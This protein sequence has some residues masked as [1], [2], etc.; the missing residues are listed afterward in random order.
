M[1]FA[2][3]NELF[4]PQPLEQTLA[5]IASIGYQG[6][7]LA[8]FTLASE[9]GRLSPQRRR[10][11]R[12]A[13]EREGLELI[14]LHWLLAQTEGLHLTTADNATRQRTM[15]YLRELGELCHDLGGG[16]MVLGSPT[17]RSLDPG[18]D[19]QTGLDRAVDL[20]QQLAP[21]LEKL[22]VRLAIEPLGPEETNFINT[23]AEGIELAKSVGSSHV[24]LHLDVK[25][26]ATESIPIPQIIR[27]SRQW[28]V[29]FHAN[30]PNRRGPGTGSVDFAPIVVAL[31]EIEYA[32]WVSVEVFDF[33]E[34]A[35]EIAESAFDFLC[36][37]WGRQ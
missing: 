3:C 21:T 4:D 19:Y 6:V 10:D 2:I 17:A 15:K 14:G 29:H 26:M 22:N 8:P 30:D 35:T 33:S 18:C 31:K 7:E 34:G 9:P 11:I 13:I 5:Q 12:Q 24:Q 28:L 36:Q 23:A 1:K 20:L 37:V 32:G 27:D 16:L 25:A